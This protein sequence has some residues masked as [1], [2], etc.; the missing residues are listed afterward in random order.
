MINHAKGTFE[1]KLTPQ[2]DKSGAIVGQM[3]IDKQFHGDIEGSSKGLM[4][5]ASTSVS[6]SAGYV[7]LER[8]EASV[9]DRNG[10]FYLQH[11][12]IMNRGEG[13]LTVV[14]IP[15][16]GTNQLTGLSGSLK[17]TIENGKH[18]YEFDYEI[19]ET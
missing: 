17:I 13:T 12:G 11:N 2:E 1:V 18:F 19:A 6:G 14:V 8:V 4:I 9:N 16:S 10:T 5:M 3:T 7:A 15:D